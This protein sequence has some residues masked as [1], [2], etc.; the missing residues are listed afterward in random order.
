MALMSQRK[1]LKEDEVSKGSGHPGFE[2]AAFMY[3]MSSGAEKNGVSTTTWAWKE[4]W[5]LDKTQ[6]LTNTLISAW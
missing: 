5:A 6:A 2:N 4:T 1:P 3:F